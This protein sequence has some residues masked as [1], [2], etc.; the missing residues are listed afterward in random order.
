MNDY[1]NRPCA[2]EGLL[3]FRYRGKY[4]YIMIGAKDVDDALNEAARSNGTAHPW[5]LEIWNGTAYVKAVA[6]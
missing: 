5:Y 1:W 2:A 6:P 3:S 4:G